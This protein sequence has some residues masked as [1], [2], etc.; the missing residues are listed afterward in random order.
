MLKKVAATLLLALAV[1]WGYVSL[2]PS[3][4]ISTSE[5]SSSFSTEKALEHLKII[6]E[7]P[8]YVGTPEHEKVKEYIAGELQKLG[9]EVSYQEAYSVT[10][11]WGSFTKPE[12]IVA[13]YPGT[14]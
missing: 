13:K 11:D 5:N 12:N 3:N 14:E 1:Y 4:T 9:F 6:S 10:E 2:K 8:H 7:K